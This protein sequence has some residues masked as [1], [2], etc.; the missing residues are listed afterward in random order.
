MNK[1]GNGNIEA[2]NVTVRI[3]EHISH[4]FFSNAYTVLYTLIREKKQTKQLL[5]SN[6]YL[7]LIH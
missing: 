1:G 5:F 6:T 7:K 3:H 4:E 2:V